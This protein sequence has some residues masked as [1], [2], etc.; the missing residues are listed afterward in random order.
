MAFR[1]VLAVLYI[2]TVLP[3]ISATTT[4]SSSSLGAGTTTAASRDVWRY[5]SIPDP[6]RDVWQCGNKG[7][8]SFLCDPNNILSDSAGTCASFCRAINEGFY[9]HLLVPGIY[10]QQRREP[11]NYRQTFDLLPI[12]CGVALCLL[13][14]F[15]SI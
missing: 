13:L 6:Q 12:C 15:V 10:R 5:L 14:S 7:R 2:I 3:Y 9:R 4:K 1:Y 8:K 11:A